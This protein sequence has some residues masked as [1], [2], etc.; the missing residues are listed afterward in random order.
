[1]VRKRREKTEQVWGAALIRGVE[2]TLCGATLDADD[3]AQLISDK[4]SQLAQFGL[5]NPPKGPR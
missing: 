4:H 5:V 1:L 3:I 2:C